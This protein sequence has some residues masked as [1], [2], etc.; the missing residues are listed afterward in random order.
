MLNWVILF[1]KKGSVLVRVHMGTFWVL[2]FLKVAPHSVAYLCQMASMPKLIYAPFDCNLSIRY[3]H[4][5]YKMTVNKN[6]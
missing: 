1:V 6:F 3:M 5:F 4:N 2:N